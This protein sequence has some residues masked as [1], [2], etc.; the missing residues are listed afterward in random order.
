MTV[1]VIPVR[2]V[3]IPNIFTPNYDGI[4][5]YFT[6]YGGPAARR[7]ESMKIFNRWGGLMYETAGIPLGEEP[8]G[9]DGTFNG[10][11]LNSGVYVYL[12]EVSFL[13]DVKFTYSGDINLIR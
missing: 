8:L 4:N 10:K 3:Y 6:A 2:P 13:D 11:V 5:D 12:I 1:T 9:W 7:I